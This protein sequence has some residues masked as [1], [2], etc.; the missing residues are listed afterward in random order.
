MDTDTPWTAKRQERGRMRGEIN[1]GKSGMTKKTRS[2]LS[3]WRSR[4]KKGGTVLNRFIGLQATTII[5]VSHSG[6]IVSGREAVEWASASLGFATQQ[7]YT[8]TRPAAPSSAWLI[9]RANYRRQRLLFRCDSNKGKRKK[10]KEEVPCICKFSRVRKQAGSIRLIPGR[11]VRSILFRC[12][13]ENPRHEPPSGS[14]VNLPWASMDAD[15]KEIFIVNDT[16]ADFSESSDTELAARKLFIGNERRLNRDSLL[17]FES[18]YWTE[19]FNAGD[20]KA[21]WNRDIVLK[22]SERWY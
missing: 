9:V 20:V 12:G 22:F 6:P 3:P 18:T 5:F 17:N 10:K 1:G 2:T 16:T 11:R 4:G 14:G 21:A 13:H 8:L 7:T 19:G 15:S